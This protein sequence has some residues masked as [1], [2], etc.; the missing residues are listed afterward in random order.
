VKSGKTVVVSLAALLVAGLGSNAF[1]RGSHRGHHHHHHHHHGPRV[2][3]YAAPVIVP[4]YYYPPA[5]SYYPP[6]AP[7]YYLE[8]PQQGYW[9][10]CPQSNAYYPHVQNCPGGWQ[11]VAPQPRSAY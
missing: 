1:A 7:T 3:F 10:Y 9:H 5:Y 2:V 6:P 11:L 4:R 8:Q